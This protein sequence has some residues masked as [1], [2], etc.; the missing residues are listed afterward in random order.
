MLPTSTPSI[1]IEIAADTPP[2]D[3]VTT[4]VPAV[5][6]A[7][8]VPDARPETV[9]AEGEIV[10][11]EAFETKKLAAVPSATF[12]P[13]LSLSVA[14]IATLPRALTVVGLAVS[15]MV[16]TVVPVVPP[17]PDTGALAPAGVGSESLE[18]PAIKTE[19]IGNNRNSTKN[20]A[21]F[22]WNLSF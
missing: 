19:H 4:T 21:D 16:A 10:P 17:V 1:G 13:V 8:N 2:A 12:A 3:T 14:D 5:L 9:V 6:S 15:V 20:R 11:N 18:Q 7:V 22:I